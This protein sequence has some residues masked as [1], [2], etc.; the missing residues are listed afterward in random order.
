MLS[1]QEIMNNALKEMLHYEA[2]TANKYAELSKQMTEPEL[3][4]RL[5]SM[6]MAA[7]SNYTLL[8]KKMSEIGMV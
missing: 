8:S 7:R 5:K 1:D 4:A 2:L 3:Q 6:E